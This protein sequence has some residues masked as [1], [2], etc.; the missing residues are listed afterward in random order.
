M[1][2]IFIFTIVLIGL[3]DLFSLNIEYNK[4]DEF[5]QMS[6]FG[7]EE[8]IHIEDNILY[9][10]TDYGLEIYEI[11]EN[12]DISLISKL[13][14]VF[15]QS[16]VYY[17]N[18]IYITTAKWH[19]DDIPN[20]LLKIDVNNIQQPT[21]V[22]E[23]Q[24][25][26][27]FSYRKIEIF[28]DYLIFY[29]RT[30]NNSNQVIDK[31][32]VFDLNNLEMLYD[33]TD[34]IGQPWKISDTKCIAP[35]GYNQYEII[36]FTDIGDPVQTG[37][38]DIN[39]QHQYNCWDIDAIND[40]LIYAVS[41][42][43]VSFW[44]ISDPFEWSLV[45]TIHIDNLLMDSGDCTIKDN[46]L[47]I[48][49][50]DNAMLIDLSDFSNI[51]FAN[52]ET[53]AFISFASTVAYEDYFYLADRFCGIRKFRF[54]DQQFE[55]CNSLTENT[56][57]F[58]SGFY[59]NYL[60]QNHYSQPISY[61]D[62]SDI[63]NV[64]SKQTL[65]L[66]H[67]YLELQ[68]IGNSIFCSDNEGVDIYDISEMENPQFISRIE[69]VVVYQF[70]QSNSDNFLYFQN[71]WQSLQKFD[72]SELTNPQLCYQLDLNYNIY[73]TIIVDDYI[74]I[75]ESNVDNQNLHVI[76]GANSNVPNEVNTIYNISN[77]PSG[78]LGLTGN[79]LTMM[80]LYGIEHNDQGV[81]FYSI[82][83]PINP[84]FIFQTSISGQVNILDDIITVLSGNS[85]YFYDIGN[86]PT[87]TIEPIESM[88]DIGYSK[89]IY[90]IN[91]NDNNFFL[92]LQDCG[93]S[94]F[95]Y[96]IEDTNSPENEIPI[97]PLNLSNYP[98]PFNPTTKISYSLPKDVQKASIEI[99]NVKGQ[100]IKSI[101][102]G[103]LS[104][105][106]Y[107][108]FWN[109]KNNNNKIVNSGVYFYKLIVDDKTVMFSK[110]MLIK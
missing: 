64:S 49:V 67:Q 25:N 33:F 6:S 90:P 60:I 101:E 63:N 82:D 66:D 16:M 74:Y 51:Y 97:T 92:Y 46:F 37:F 107:D 7:G 18:N 50:V 24:F 45:H 11:D 1:K 87:G 55:Y 39:S 5:S 36:D 56:F 22:A 81:K 68:I 95:S 28:N 65:N 70:I 47:F 2:K 77:L 17:Q 73:T 41:A 89:R 71:S 59:Q 10:Y 4:L 9:T 13:Q 110:M 100:K 91:Q 27:F 94:T 3:T 31:N 8:S 52:Y 15:A 106:Q 72:I 19:F 53:S 88:I 30:V 96:N 54:Q 85:C 44:D 83:D 62:F 102:C 34:L 26:L 80:Y 48:P 103:N 109:G 12:G 40:T 79:Y 76:M 35:R 61:Y 86:N 75:C 38:G 57:T 93:V 58:W 98:N 69:N 23:Y 14:L 43:N 108:I 84:E 99:F 21:I 78:Y 32:L 29:Y 105:G 42:Y 104:L 20:R